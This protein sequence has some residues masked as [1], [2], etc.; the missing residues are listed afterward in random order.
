[1]AAI[2]FKFLVC[3]ALILLSSSATTT[4]TTQARVIKP[5]RVAREALQ[6]MQFEME[7]NAA[8]NGLPERVAPGGPDPHH[9]FLP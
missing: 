9:H 6:K 5:M 3:L 2:R 1:M 8:V 4:K 7:K